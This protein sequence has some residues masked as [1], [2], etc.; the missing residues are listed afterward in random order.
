MSVQQQG[1]ST[2]EYNIGFLV[3]QVCIKDFC[4]SLILY[5]WYKSGT[6]RS[7]PLHQHFCSAIWGGISPYFW[8]FP[9]HT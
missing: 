3:H 4:P 7:A 1:E 5:K 8:P 2:L 9:L 6:Q